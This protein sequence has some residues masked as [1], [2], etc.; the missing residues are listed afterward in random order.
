MAGESLKDSA[1]LQS[2]KDLF[3]DLADLLQKE[4]RLARAEMTAALTGAVQAGVWMAAAGLL[5]LIAA[6][7]FLQ[8]V[9]FGIASLGVG[10][11]WASLIVAVLLAASAAGAFFYGRSLTKGSVAPKRTLRQ[12]NEDIGAVREQL[13]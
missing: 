3:S 1:L 9:V 10:V 12:I 7:F 4:F 13:T 2:V 5:G 11:G 6:L 8:A